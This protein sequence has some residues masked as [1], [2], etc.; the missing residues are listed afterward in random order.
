M[1][2]LFFT[3][4]YLA[5][6]SAL[7]H[8]DH[9]SFELP[10]DMIWLFWLQVLDSPPC[11]S[12]KS[13]FIPKLWPTSWATSYQRRVCF[14]NNIKSSLQKEKYYPSKCNR[15]CTPFIDRG[16]P[17]IRGRTG[18][19]YRA[20]GNANDSPKWTF[21]ICHIYNQISGSYDCWSMRFD[22]FK[23]ISTGNNFCIKILK[24]ANPFKFDLSAKCGMAIT[25]LNMGSSCIPISNNCSFIA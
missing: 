18:T 21:I 10:Y 2:Q 9:F 25:C 17:G 11:A 1:H 8:V 5:S 22:S 4:K 3:C 7:L 19:N 16:F 23:I 20:P 15:S 6:K 14:Y 12:S 13:C 24:V